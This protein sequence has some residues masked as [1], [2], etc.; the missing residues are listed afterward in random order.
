MTNIAQTINVLQAMILTDKERMLRTPTF[1]VFEM[2]KVHQGGTFLPVELETPEYTLGGESI[3]AVSASA[4]RNDAG[5]I[6]LSLINTDASSEV[7]IRCSL[8]GVSVTS[9]TGRLLT[10]AK[11]NSHNTFDQPDTV[12]PVAFADATI[13][14]GDLVTVLPAKSVIVF[15]LRTSP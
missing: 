4:T 2:F 6:H 5:V 9:V 8:Q 1:H 3:P 10:A 14:A 11:I 13:E 15:E 7:P 12:K